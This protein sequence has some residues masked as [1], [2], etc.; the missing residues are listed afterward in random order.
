MWS[1]E[2]DG[3]AGAPP[4]SLVWSYQTGNGCREGICGWG[5]QEKQSYTTDPANVALDGHGHLAIVARRAIPGLA[6][7]SGPC[8][9]TSGRLITQRARLAQPGRVEARIVIPQGQGLWPA[10]WMLGASDPVAPWPQR[11]ELDIME[12]HGSAPQATSSAI[13]GPGYSGRTPFAKSVHLADSASFAAGF[14]LFAVEWDAAGVRFSVDNQPH[15]TVTRREVEQRG[16]WVFEQPFAIL[17][18]LAVGG[19][20]DGDPRSEDIL[21]ATM[22]V[23]YVRVY[24][25][26]A[27]P[28]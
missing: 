10:F 6:C 1:D 18:N 25:A 26:R 23:D 20:F 14:H 7:R 11:G 21:P 9:Y 28:D 22:L 3:P 19:T 12:N 16:V 2:F 15:Y 8:R 13:H 17:L 4:D 5:N 24:I 27:Q